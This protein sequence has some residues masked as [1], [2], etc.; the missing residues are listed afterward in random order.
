MRCDYSFSSPVWSLITDDAK[1]FVSSLIVLNPK[2][3]LNAKQ[4][5]EHAWIKNQESLSN[6]IPPVELMEGIEASLLNY[7]NASELKK[8]ALNVIAHKSSSEEIVMMRDAFR[9]YDTEKD[10]YI[11]YDE[12]C[13]ALKECSLDEKTLNSVFNSIDVDKNGK[14]SY[15]EFLAAA[16]EARTNID[17]ERVADAFDHL[18][19]SDT[20]FISKEDLASLLG[21]DKN[22][23]DVQRLIQGADTDK[24]GKISFQEFLAVFR[25]EERR[26][27]HAVVSIESENTNGDSANLMGLDAVIPGGKFDKASN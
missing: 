12:F 17:E 24:D 7:A 13:N 15:C 19:H 21:H 5:L 9:H 20:G 2:E 27:A 25:K 4:A 8:M 23:E 16:L 3:R 26:L 14:I 1:D 10:G 11:S 22:S 6:D 18:D